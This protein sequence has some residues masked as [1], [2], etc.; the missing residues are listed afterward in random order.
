MFVS[1]DADP[2]SVI[3]DVIVDCT[4]WDVEL[5]VFKGVDDEV[6]PI[7]CAVDSFGGSCAIVVDDNI[8]MMKT[9]AR[10]PKLAFMLWKL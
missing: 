3:L 9:E 2:D 4:A 1:V 8:E 7:V 10:V 5:G 6:V